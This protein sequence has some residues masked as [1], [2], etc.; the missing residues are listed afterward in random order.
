MVS[1][2]SNG[3]PHLVVLNFSKDMVAGKIGR[4]RSAEQKSSTDSSADLYTAPEIGNPIHRL[5]LFNVLSK[6]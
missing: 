5:W 3:R 1:L 2:L 4:P 6:S